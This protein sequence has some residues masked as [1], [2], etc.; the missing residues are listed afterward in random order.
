MA[1]KKTDPREVYDL[2]RE[3]K[4]FSGAV[5]LHVVE[6]GDPANPGI[7]FLHGFP[8]DHHVWSRQF[9]D[10]KRDFHVISFDMRG[11]GESS[12][13]EG[14]RAYRIEH[15]LPDIAAIPVSWI[16]GF[17]PDSPLLV[18]AE[19]ILYQIPVIYSS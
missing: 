2:E 10:L 11:V 1:K 13:P 7:L 19:Y 6:A 9:H 8:D 4:V 15:V 12:N 17:F 3:R 5:E 18:C 16:H 14:K